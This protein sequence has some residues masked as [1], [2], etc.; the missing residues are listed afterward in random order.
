MLSKVSMTSMGMGILA[1]GVATVMFVIERGAPGQAWVASIGG[2][3]LMFA[4]LGVA[5]WLLTALIA[6]WTE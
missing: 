2:P 6:V 4:G 5:G 1:M 3:A